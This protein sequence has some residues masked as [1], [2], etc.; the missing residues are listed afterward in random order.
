MSKKAP[1][2]YSGYHQVEFYPNGNC[3]TIVAYID[4]YWEAGGY[5][6]K[7][8]AGQSV[9]FHDNGSVKKLTLAGESVINFNGESVLLAAESDVEFKIN[10]AIKCFTVGKQNRGYIF[11]DHNWQYNGQTYEPGSKVEL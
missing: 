8:M 1:E 5:R 7:S 10:G 2:S 9:E 3:R 6:L 4:E 11:K